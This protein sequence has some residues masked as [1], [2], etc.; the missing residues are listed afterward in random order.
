[1]MERNVSAMKRNNEGSPDNVDVEEECMNGVRCIII[2]Q[3]TK[4]RDEVKMELS[5]Q[6]FGF[7]REHAFVK[8]SMPRPPFTLNNNLRGQ[9]PR[10]A[11]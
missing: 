3:H 4:W 1:M 11:G 7:V 2:Y 8:A 6:K 5:F 9:S 10:E